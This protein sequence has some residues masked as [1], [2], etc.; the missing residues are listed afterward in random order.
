MILFL[1]FDGVLHPD[2]V[3]ITRGGPKLR[4]DGELFMWA[5]VLE[6]ILYDFPGVRIVLSTSWVRQLGFAKTK[7]H[8]TVALQTKIVGSTWHSSMAKDLSNTVWWD[9]ATR[10]DQIARY[11]ARS[12]VQDWVALDDD[13][14]GWHADRLDRLVLAESSLGLS[15]P[16][17]Q[18]KLKSL[19]ATTGGCRR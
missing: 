13:V 6:G 18:L 15:D 17:T 10:H 3:Y 12:R 9:Q 5:T 8:L 7:K 14:Q 19:L 16:V 2:E 1:D 4:S 11:V